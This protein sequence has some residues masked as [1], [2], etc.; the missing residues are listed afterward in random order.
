MPND[1]IMPAVP[2]KRLRL[3]NVTLCAISSSNVH[4]TIQA[5]E[6]SLA[7][8]DVA[9][10]I[11]FTDD[12][13]TR[14]T[15]ALAADI[16]VVQIDKIAS[17]EAYSHFVLERLVDYIR[18]SHC[19]IV[20]WDGHVVDPAHWRPEFLQYDYIGAR[21]PQFDDGYDVGNG[22]FSLRSRALM[23][24]CR[25]EGFRC[26][27]PEDLATGRTNRKFLEGLGMRFAPAKLADDFAAERAGDPA[28]S[29]GY[30]GVFLM[31]YVLGADQFWDIYRKLDD[32]YSLRR[33]FADLLKA[34]QSG[35]NSALRSLRMICNRVGDYFVRRA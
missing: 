30:H 9:E 11:L 25:M 22:G 35:E 1:G 2:R 16:R 4:A 21:W 8:V 14:Q 23:E 5:L 13:P 31:P 12:D 20:Q 18:T 7:Y 33:D 19:L 10:A 32:R 15:T 28:A 3:E 24:A 27:H 26:H 34:L 6:T 29:F 17:S